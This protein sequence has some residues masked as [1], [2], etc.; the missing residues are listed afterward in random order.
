MI[1]SIQRYLINFSNIRCEVF[2]RFFYLEIVQI[3]AKI[4]TA[5]VSRFR[6]NGSSKPGGAAGTQLPSTK[7]VY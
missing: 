4:Y 1:F 7:E 2:C 5:F 6:A 3:Y